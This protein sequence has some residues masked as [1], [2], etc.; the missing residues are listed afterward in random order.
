[1]VSKNKV[2]SFWKKLHWLL[3]WS[4]CKHQWSVDVEYVCFLSIDRRTLPTFCFCC[5]CDVYCYPVPYDRDTF[6]QKRFATLI[7]C[8]RNNSILK[9][10]HVSVFSKARCFLCIFWMKHRTPFGKATWIWI[11][12]SVWMFKGYK[13]V[14]QYLG[15]YYQPWMPQQPTSKQCCCFCRNI[16]YITP[17]TIYFRNRNKNLIGSKYPTKKLFNFDEQHHWFQRSSGQ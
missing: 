10:E 15:L 1:M 6:E 3:V 9:H 5:T 13:K 2:I 12:E 8:N 11:S 7:L 16:H 17:K 14:L 4:V